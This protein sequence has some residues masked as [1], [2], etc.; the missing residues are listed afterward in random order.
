MDAFV[1]EIG[2]PILRAGIPGL[3]ERARQMLEANHE[4]RFICDV[5]ALIDPDAAMVDAL[6][7]LQLTA[8][9]LGRRVE[10]IDAGEELRDLLAWMG[11]DDVIP[12]CAKL[13]LEPER[14]SEQREQTRGVQ[15]EAD[16]A[17]PIS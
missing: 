6:A 2:G 3:C 16:P 14:Q 4:A 11:L 13:S 7:R 17:D 10:L 9:R 15:E 12:L 8:L 5:G 1:L